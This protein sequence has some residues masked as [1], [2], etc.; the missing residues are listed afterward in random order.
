[1]QLA[2]VWQCG[3]ML[4]TMLFGKFPFA[5]ESKLSKVCAVSSLI[6]FPSAQ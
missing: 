4:Y 3:V 1:M 5:S 2:D 6:L